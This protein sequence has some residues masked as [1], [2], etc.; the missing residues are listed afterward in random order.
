FE[1]AHPG[2]NLELVEYKPD[3]KEYYDGGLQEAEADIY[4]IDTVLLPEM[5][6]AGKIAPLTLPSGD[7]LP[8]ARQAVQFNGSTWAVP[9]WV[10]GNFVFYRVGDTTIENAKTWDE[11]VAA[12]GKNTSWFVDLKGKSTLG[13]WYLTAI[14]GLN[15]DPASVVN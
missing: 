13:E 1:A 6:R 15:G 4:E 11:L 2:V 5:I 7:F 9:H 12:F 8:E 3:M 14:A 10:C